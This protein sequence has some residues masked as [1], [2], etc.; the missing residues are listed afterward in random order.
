MSKEKKDRTI[1]AVGTLVVHA[2]IVL[3]LFLMAFR[4]P[5][6]LPGEEGVEVDLGMYNQGMGEVQPDKSAIPQQSLPPKPQE[7]ENVKSKDDV[8]TQDT[9][10]APS[11]KTEKKKEVKEETE[12]KPTETLKEPE[13]P[14][15]VVN[16]KALFKGSDKS[17]DGGS[18]GITGQPG[19][20]G[21]PN[22]LAGI[23]KYDGHGGQGNGAGYDL[24]GR[25][26][27]T[28]QRPSKDFPEEG[29]IVVEI[30][31]DQEGNV[32]R[33]NIAK[34]TDITNTEMRNMALEAA[35]RSKFIADPT[36]PEEQK[37]TITYTFVQNQ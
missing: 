26:A 3:A 34:G 14:K 24:G 35:R 29:H 7:E 25:G 16:P 13:E 2:L 1:A 18:Q 31:V 20:Q 23:N 12:T 9:E 32:V 11:I 5:L 10:E 27:K 30:F 17:Q 19:D 28:L 6:P 8:V 4:T 37:G 22:G 36:A 15:P 33:A 21:N